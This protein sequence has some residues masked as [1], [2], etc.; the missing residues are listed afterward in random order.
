MA[1]VRAKNPAFELGTWVNGVR[2][3]TH[4]SSHMNAL[5]DHIELVSDE[6]IALFAVYGIVGGVCDFG[7]ES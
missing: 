6:T 3:D 1:P 2:L 5:S 7:A 4:V